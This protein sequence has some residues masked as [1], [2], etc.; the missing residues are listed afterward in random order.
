MNMKHG[1]LLV[2]S[3]IV[4]AFGVPDR[5]LAA[6]PKRSIEMEIRLPNAV[7]L[8]VTVRDTEGVTLPLPDHTTFGF[9]ATIRDDHDPA[10]VLVTIWKVRKNATD[11]LGE[12]EAVVGGPAVVSHTTP[13]FGVRIVR[14]IAPTS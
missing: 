12:V 10:V 7:T 13:P 6:G 14:M 4:S 2:A 8:H 3:L 1:S 11:R 9:V 5:A